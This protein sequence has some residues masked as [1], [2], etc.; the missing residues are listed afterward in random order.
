[1]IVGGLNMKYVVG[2]GLVAIPAGSLYI[3]TDGVRRA[4]VLNFMNPFADVK[5]TGYQ[6]VQGLYAIGSGGFFGLGLGSSR[7]K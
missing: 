1:M 5:L 3:M 4:R 6:V 7:Q 2:C